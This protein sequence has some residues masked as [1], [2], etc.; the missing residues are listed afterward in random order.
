MTTTNKNKKEK[1]QQ[2]SI[3]DGFKTL[4]STRNFGREIA[5][6]YQKEVIEVI[7]ITLSIYIVEF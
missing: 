3:I 5:S 7:R 1:T 2:L 4:F 6:K